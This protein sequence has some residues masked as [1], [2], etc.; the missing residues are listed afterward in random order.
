MRKRADLVTPLRALP[1]MRTR[2]DAPTERNS[3]NTTEPRLP[4]TNSGCKRCLKR[5]WGG[6]N[7]LKRWEATARETM[8]ETRQGWQKRPTIAP[9]FGATRCASP[10]ML[11]NYQTPTIS[12]TASRKR[13]RIGGACAACNPAEPTSTRRTCMVSLGRETQDTTPAQWQTN[14]KAYRPPP[15]M[16]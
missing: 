10:R 11:P 5:A 8:H 16:D 13:H 15:Y 3:Q 6:F 4:A 1:R 7:K 9:P 12:R 2:L 14:R